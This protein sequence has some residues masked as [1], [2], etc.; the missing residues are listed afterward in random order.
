LHRIQNAGASDVWSNPAGTRQ[1]WHESRHL[2]CYLTDYIFV[3]FSYFIKKE[4]D[5]G[6]NFVLVSD[7]R[8]SL[9]INPFF[10]AVAFLKKNSEGEWFVDLSSLISWHLSLGLSREN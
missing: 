1:R 3:F 5:F 2:A 10:H 8:C 7:T 6:C 4:K 9:V